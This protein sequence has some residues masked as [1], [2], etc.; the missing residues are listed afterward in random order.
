VI[1]LTA[2]QSFQQ[3]S[4]ILPDSYTIKNGKSGVKKLE[5]ETDH[6]AP[7]NAR[8]ERVDSLLSLSTILSFSA[9]C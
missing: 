2:F 3:G 7:C 4:G 9:Q 5:H 1:F 8:E 6:L